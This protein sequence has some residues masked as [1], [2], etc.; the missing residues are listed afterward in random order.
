MNSYQEKLEIYL[1]EQ[2]HYLRQL[3]ATIMLADLGSVEEETRLHFQD[4]LPKNMEFATDI[5]LPEPITRLKSINVL[6]VN[7]LHHYLNSFGAINDDPDTESDVDVDEISDAETIEY[8]PG[9]N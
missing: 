7:F 2:N 9:N 8:E 3:T 4:L 1:R 6:L 5:E